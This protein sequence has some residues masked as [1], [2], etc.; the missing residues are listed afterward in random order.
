MTS[1]QKPFLFLDKINPKYKNNELAFQ[2]PSSILKHAA[3]SFTDES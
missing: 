1:D 2:H 3:Q